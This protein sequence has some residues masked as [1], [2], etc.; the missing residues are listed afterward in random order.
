MLRL[1]NGAQP[2]YLEVQA[3]AWRQGVQVVDHGDH[4]MLALE[5]FGHQGAA[6]AAQTTDQDQFE[7]WGFGIFHQ[8]TPFSGG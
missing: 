7:H 5:Q 1:I 3:R 4:F 2:A 6:Q 8:V